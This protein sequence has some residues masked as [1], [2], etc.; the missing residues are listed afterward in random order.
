MSTP[1]IVAL[2]LDL[3]GATEFNIRF[4][5]TGA[6]TWTDYYTTGSTLEDLSSALL[7]GDVYTLD[8]INGPT[9]NMAAAS[10]GGNE[11]QARRKTAG[12]YGNWSAPAAVEWSP[13]SDGPLANPA[14][15]LRDFLDLKAALDFP[16]QEEAHAYAAGLLADASDEVR[17]YPGVDAVYTGGPTALQTRQLARIERYM[18]TALALEKAAVQR[19]TG[20]HAPLLFEESA[21]L[22][23]LAEYF[24]G[25]SERLLT[26]FTD[27]LGGGT[28]TLGDIETGTLTLP[29]SERSPFSVYEEDLV[30]GL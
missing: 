1:R 8:G 30:Y 17:G 3:D 11:Y 18:A 15:L 29:F 7:D 27:A 4:R 10:Y 5:Q 23:A 16:S 9:G 21:D 28:A 6:P 12:G 26:S 25:Q 22:Q 14:G 19:A 24:R 13:V 2:T 20:T